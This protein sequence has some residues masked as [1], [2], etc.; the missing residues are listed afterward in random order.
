YLVE[1]NPLFGVGQ[2]FVGSH[3][4]EERYGYNPDTIQKHLGNA[5][6][7]AWLIR[8]QLVAQTGHNI[9]AGYADEAKQMR[10]LLDN[11]YNQGTGLGLTYGVAPSPEQLAGLKQ[12]IVWMVSQVVE[13]QSVLVPVVYLAKSTVDSLES[14]AAIAGGDV[15]LNL[16]SLDN[17]GGTIA[18]KNS[19]A[20]ASTGDISNISG[21]LKGGDVSLVSSAGNVVNRTQEV[22]D[23]NLSTVLGKTAGISAT[24]NLNVS[25]A[26]DVVV[27]GGTVDAGKDA[28][29]A[30][31]GNVTLDTVEKVATET[32]HSSDSSKFGGL[33]LSSGSEVKTTTMA[34]NVGSSLT[35]GGKLAIRAGKDIAIA[36]S[37]VKSGG[38]LDL[39][40]KGDV[41][42]VARQDRVTTHT[43]SHQEG[44]GVGGGLWGSERVVKD[45]F[46]GKNFASS[47]DAG[48]NAKLK[49]GNTI[50]L[51]GSDLN[52]AGNADIDARDIQV[53]AG[54]DEK[55]SHTETDSLTLIS[56]ATSKTGTHTG[57]EAGA[58]VKGREA[59]AAASAEA[60]ASADAS[61]KLFS[62]RKETT[63]TLDSVSRGSNLNI[64]GNLNA[65]ATN[66]ITL[67]GAQVATGG[68]LNLDGRNANVLAA[69][70]VHTS[71]TTAKEIAINLSASALASA[72]L[73]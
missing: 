55:R 31:G 42:V 5:N 62:S 54:K 36:G 52:V 59:S 37:K 28:S 35:T 7:E 68:D 1:T 17:V 71:T 43:E 48:G 18:G 12:D 72:L 24:G 2:N 69:Q 38:D 58:G 26:K 33:T 57:A 73:E 61:V 45:E 14:G 16:T 51:E 22:G 50:K 34:Q 46:E 11:A 41:N 6:Y 9:L 30:A 44:V 39:D 25:A 47:I 29:I 15:N 3:Y 67:Q 65:R 8:Q 40:A 27:K 21:N 49:S 53:L 70:D 64:R 56:G 20:I 60:G 13:G 23:R 4:L 32:T 63:D 19:L 66:D 10:R